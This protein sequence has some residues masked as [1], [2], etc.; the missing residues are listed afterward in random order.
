MMKTLDF[1]FSCESRRKDHLGSTRFV[2]AA[3][4]SG[5][6]SC[7]EAYMFD[8]YGKKYLIMA[9]G[10]EGVKEIFTGKEF[11]EEIGRWVSSDTQQEFW[12]SYSY[13]GGNPVGFV[14]FEGLLSAYFNRAAQTVTLYSK[15]GEFLRVLPAANNVDS[16][17]V[18]KK[19]RFPNG[20]RNVKGPIDHTK[21]GKDEYQQY[22]STN[23]VFNMGPNWDGIGLHAGRVG[24]FDQA[25]RTGY[26]FA[27]FGCIRTTQ[28]AL[29]TA[30]L[31]AAA[32]INNLVSNEL[33]IA[34]RR[35]TVAENASSTTA[36][37]ATNEPVQTPQSQKN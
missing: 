14:D 33:A 4:G 16:K 20:T 35:K 6:G 1:N 5:A 13:V 15:N 34:R 22:G 30:I 17:V 11:D 37:K 24:E 3:N 27:T 25:G 26:Q 29:D 8:A 23:Y 31:N 2:L 7:A 10:G 9:P 18:E 28:E 12:D 19:G 36:E 32:A 21:H